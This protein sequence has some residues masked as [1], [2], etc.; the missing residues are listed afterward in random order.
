MLRSSSNL[1]VSLGRTR[2]VLE[3]LEWRLRLQAATD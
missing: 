2:D 3:M 1:M